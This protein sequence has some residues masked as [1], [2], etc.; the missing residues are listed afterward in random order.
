MGKVISILPAQR[1][2]YEQEREREKDRIIQKILGE[3]PNHTTLRQLLLRQAIELG[4][5]NWD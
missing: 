5:F 2:K 1:R 4:Y 3:D